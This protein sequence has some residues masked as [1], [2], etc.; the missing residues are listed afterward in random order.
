MCS[1]RGYEDILAGVNH[2]VKYVFAI[3]AFFLQFFLVWV[4]KAGRMGV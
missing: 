2:Q 4:E 3:F 1:F